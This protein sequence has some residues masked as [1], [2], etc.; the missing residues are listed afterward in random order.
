[1]SSMLTN[2]WFDRLFLYFH[3]E[4]SSNMPNSS[5]KM[6]FSDF[7][8]KTEKRKKTCYISIVI[9]TKKK[10]IY[11]YT[12]YMACCSKNLTWIIRILLK[13]QGLSPQFW[14]YKT[15][16]SF[17]VAWWSWHFFTI[18]FHNRSLRMLTIFFI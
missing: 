13:Y 14:F 15:Y 1:M 11:I 2:Y 17:D 3:Y 10:S 18:I 8:N 4:S 5:S 12:R 16:Y 6:W 9:S 7:K